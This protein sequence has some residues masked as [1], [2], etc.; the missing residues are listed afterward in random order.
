MPMKMA[1]K[2]RHKMSCYDYAWESQDMKDCLA[3]PG[4]GQKTM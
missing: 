3:K 4:S 1:H 2:S